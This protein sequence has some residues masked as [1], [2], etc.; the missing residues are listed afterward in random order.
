[1]LEELVEVVLGEVE[2]RFLV[3]LDL[4][5]DGLILALDLKLRLIDLLYALLVVLESHLQLVLR[6]KALVHDLLDL[7]RAAVALLLSQ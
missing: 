2:A 5:E 1:M 7:L 4:L 3:L 6:V